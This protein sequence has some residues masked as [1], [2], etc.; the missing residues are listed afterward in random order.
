MNGCGWL[1]RFGLV[2]AGAVAS[3]CGGSVAKDSASTVGHDGGTSIDAAAVVDAAREPVDAGAEAS[4]CG[5]LAAP[6][7]K[8]G[9]VCP[10]GRTC[11]VNGCR[12]GESCDTSTS[13]CVPSP[14]GCG[15][16]G[17][18]YDGGAPPTG[19]VGLDGGAMSRLYFAVVGDTRPPSEDD[20]AG[21]PTA[22]ITRIFDDV[23][24]LSPRPPFVI[25]TGDYQYAAPT[26]TQGATQLDL[27]NGARSHYS[28]LQFPTMGNHEC[29]G[30]TNSNCGAGNADGITN[31]Y[32]AYLQKMLAPIQQTGPY[33][34]IDLA[35]PDGSWTAK[36]L[37]VAAN[38]WTA[39]QGTWLD[40]AMSK[41]TTY[42]FLVRHEGGTSSTAPGVS[43][44]ELIM[45]RHPYTLSIVGHAHSYYLTGVREVTI[46]N[47]GAPLSGGVN[48][49]FGMVSQQPDGFSPL[50]A[51]GLLGVISPTRAPFVSAAL[52]TLAS[53]G[54]TS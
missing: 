38:A 35:A 26:G 49:G 2:T 32:T 18:P 52:N 20:T 25:S 10:A 43:P 48:Y 41:P 42:T 9:C 11:D 54:V 37:F 51:A 1:L 34:E 16:P 24:A 23:E 53:A 15:T 5:S 31:N 46:G 39:D 28:G 33:Y 40:A 36:F 47:G 27:Y 30:Y 13:T 22:I 29:T 6:G 3:A 19:S 4:A 44:S 50:C 17:T 14:V 7:T 8:A 45:G 12:H 21:Y